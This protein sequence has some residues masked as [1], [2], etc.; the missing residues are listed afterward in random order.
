MVRVRDLQSK[1]GCLSAGARDGALKVEGC[2][3][4]VVKT[5]VNQLFR[6]SPGNVTTQNGEVGYVFSW[7]AGGAV[8]NRKRC[9]R[10]SW[11]SLFLGGRGF[12]QNR[13]LEF[14][15]KC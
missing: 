12:F 10:S 15:C 13:S 8:D 1:N 5:P 3:K 4:E 11:V 2:V 14:L 7:W 9:L 6:F